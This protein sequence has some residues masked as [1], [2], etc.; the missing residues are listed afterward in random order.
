VLVLGLSWVDSFSCRF[1]QACGGHGYLLS[2]GLPVLLGDIVQTVTAEGE[3][4][5]LSLQTGRALLKALADFRAGAPLPDAMKYL[6]NVDKASTPVQ[7]SQAQWLDPA[8][9]VTAYERRFLYLLRDLERR[10]AQSRSVAAGVQNHSVACYKLSMAY[11]KLVLVSSFVAA[12]AS[13]RAFTTEPLSSAQPLEI[14][15]LLCHL[16]ALSQLEL[17]AGEF[18]ESGAMAPA[19]LTRVRAAV[20]ALLPQLRPHAVV[21]VDA[22]NFTDHTLNSTLG[23]A[24]GNVYEALYA[25][26]QH[27]PVNRASDKIALHDLLLPIRAAVQAKL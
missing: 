3:N 11:A 13:P 8:H 14:V 20:E 5:V 17:D 9:Y 18:M 26:A 12:V 6:A 16:F 4:Y 22:F 19:D 2:S 27:D 24:D 1:P 21:L 7:R 25:S 15:R 23:R 10:V